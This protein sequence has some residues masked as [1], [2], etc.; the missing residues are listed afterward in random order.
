MFRAKGYFRAFHNRVPCWGSIGLYNRVP[1]K[2]SIGFAFRLSRAS[3]RGLWIRAFLYY[4]DKTDQID[5]DF[6]KKRFDV[7]EGTGSHGVSC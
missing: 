3:S 2:G 7:P 1:G 5:L 6:L 4:R